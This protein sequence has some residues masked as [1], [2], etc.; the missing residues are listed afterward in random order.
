MI[1]KDGINWFDEHDADEAFSSLNPRNN[2]N[3]NIK[4]ANNGKEGFQQRSTDDFR[5]P[6]GMNSHVGTSPTY[7]RVGGNGWGSTFRNPFQTSS[8]DDFKRPHGM[9]VGME[10]KAPPPREIDPRAFKA[11]FQTSSTD[12]FKRSRD[13]GTSEFAPQQ[14]MYQEMN[15]EQQ[16]SPPPMASPT[17][18]ILNT[19]PRP[20][21]QNSVGRD[22]YEST[23][24]P[25]VFSDAEIISDVTATSATQQPMRNTA[26]EGVYEPPIID[27]RCTNDANNNND[28]NALHQMNTVVNEN[29]INAAAQQYHDKTTPPSW[30]GS[31][32]RAPPV[33]NNQ[34]ITNSPPPPPNQVHTPPPTRQTQSTSRQVA[35]GTAVKHEHD[36]EQW[37]KK[38][39]VAVQTTSKTLLRLPKFPTNKDPVGVSNE[40]PNLS[41]R[42]LVI[43]FATLSTRYL[44]LYQGHSPI[45][46]SS[47]ITLL[48]STCFDK[49]FGQ[50]AL[51]GSFA[52]MCGGHLV[53]NLS[54]A[55][56]LGG[57][58]SLCYETLV[59]INNLC[60]GIGGRL[61]ATAFLAT[62]IL[63]KYSSIGGVGRKLR[64][65]MWGK[66][67]P[68]SIVV[69]MIL[70]HILGSV[71]TIFLREC[72][73]DSAV[74]DPVRSSSVVGL[75]GSLFIKDPMS[76]LALYGGSFVGMALPSRLMHGNAPK[77]PTAA[78]SQTALA[79]FT[80]FAGAGAIAGLI[81]AFTIHSGYWNGGWGGKAGLCAFAGCWVYR[82]IASTLQFATQR[83]V[84]PV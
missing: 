69:S 27:H 14:P 71:S 65:G 26:N 72:S 83:H 1:T 78:Q 39:E 29:T 20:G 66:K 42:V 17:H 47:A 53:P 57:L 79:L 73:D 33:N 30:F 49:R 80:S 3:S 40:H 31:N 44:H 58:T 28:A 59:G 70:F 77:R 34:V 63:A 8:T 10:D 74:A 16:Q 46:A 4:N 48:V 35:P 62:S 61:G 15:R 82:G 19:T 45:L 64:R 2:N 56:V 60:L 43:M 11:P 24:S 21:Y 41:L 37:D 18:D 38:L 84:T 52:G 13:T 5:K 50:V 25:K 12:D 7:Q 6:H 68:S 54:M 55:M 51:C 32:S 76:L 9:P 81:H 75:V 67:G 36:L 23:Q 22:S